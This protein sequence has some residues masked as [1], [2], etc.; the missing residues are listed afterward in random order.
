M[1]LPPVFMRPLPR[2]RTLQATLPFLVAVLLMQAQGADAQQQYEDGAFDVD[3]DGVLIDWSV[4]GPFIDPEGAPGGGVDA[5]APRSGGNPE[6]YLRPQLTS[7]TVALGESW[8]VW[9]VHI[10]DEAVYDPASL[11]AI[12]RV[13]FDFDS[14]VPPGGRGT[15]ALSFAVQQDGFLWAAIAERELIGELSW[16]STSIS[17]L[18]AS[19]FTPHIWTEDGQAPIPDFSE[20]G[21]PIS[22][23]LVQGQSCPTTADCSAP[24]TPIEVDVDNWAVKVNETG[25]SIELTVDQIAA[26]G[27]LE[28]PLPLQFTVSARVRNAGSVDLSDI[29]VR[30]LLPKEALAGFSVPSECTPDSASSNEA[31]IVDCT[32]AG[33][34]GPAD[35]DTVRVPTGVLSD[36]PPKAII[37]VGYA[38]VVADE[39]AFTYQAEIRSFLGRDPEPGDVLIDEVVVSVC[40]PTGFDPIPV[41]DTTNCDELPTG[42]TSGAGG[43]SGT[44]GVGGAGGGMGSSGGGCG[45]FTTT[46][47]GSNPWLPFLC[48]AAVAIWRRLRRR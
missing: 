4:Y 23:G 15:R 43:S 36:D 1:I 46:A 21:S 41:E 14:R 38:G 33:P 2:I 7:V 47:N 3:G 45:C 25:L 5:S 29:E 10:N 18:Q 13:D 42:G 48:L 16:T 27:E 19:D 32:I 35:S 26:N 24:P 8:A 22:F 17:G 11:G 37:A 31:V 40:N 12:E 34:V 39:S 30:F 44:G 28:D 6:A 20:N 9:G